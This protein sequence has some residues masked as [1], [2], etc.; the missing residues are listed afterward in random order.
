MFL[1]F[2]NYCLFGQLLG[3]E[4]L[5]KTA[6]KINKMLLLYSEMVWHFD[7]RRFIEIFP[8]I[9]LI[10]TKNHQI[11]LITIN[12]LLFW[13][14][15]STRDFYFALRAFVYRNI[16]DISIF[17]CSQ[18]TKIGSEVRNNLTLLH[19]NIKRILLNVSKISIKLPFF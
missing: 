10:T 4:S 12:L 15:V 17:I 19:I 2:F 9:S 18:L 7:D 11:L 16:S 8:K 6:K 3:K 5:F 13:S 1:N 14:L